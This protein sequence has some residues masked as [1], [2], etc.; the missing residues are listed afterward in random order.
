MNKKL[1]N[2][3]ENDMNAAS[4]LLNILLGKIIVKGYTHQYEIRNYHIISCDYILFDA[5]FN[6]ETKPCARHWSN[7]LLA[8]VYAEPGNFVN[9]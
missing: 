9:N 3:F 4:E 8:L 6:G 7:G 2:K 1:F 5:K